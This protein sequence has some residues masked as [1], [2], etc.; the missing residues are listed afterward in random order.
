MKAYSGLFKSSNIAGGIVTG[1]HCQ[2]LKKTV[3]VLCKMHV[4]FFV[5]T[6]LLAWETVFVEYLHSVRRCSLV[7][8]LA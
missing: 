5:M 2:L 4:F 1:E 7:F 6:V 3:M 8:K